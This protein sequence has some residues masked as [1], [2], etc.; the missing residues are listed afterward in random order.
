[1]RGE[2]DWAAVPVLLRTIRDDDPVLRR[3]SDL[4]LRRVTGHEPIQVLGRSTSREEAGR[5]A[6]RWIAW[7][8]RNSPTRGK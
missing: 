8:G 4:A 2:S 5:I 6:D 3:N 1:V 7:T